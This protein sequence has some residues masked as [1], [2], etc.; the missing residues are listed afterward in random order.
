[1][2]S[3]PI[4]R[5]PFDVTQTYSRI[6]GRRGSKCRV[7]CSIHAG[8]KDHE[9]YASHL[10]RSPGEQKRH[11]QLRRFSTPIQIQPRPKRP[12]PARDEKLTWESVGVS[13]REGGRHFKS[14]ESAARPRV[15]HDPAYWPL[16]RTFVRSASLNTDGVANIITG[17]AAAQAKGCHTKFS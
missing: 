2:E 15:L 3:W 12:E 8:P 9:I 13:L 7:A 16:H 17:A 6:G 10:G 14:S 5:S 1:M 4:T 11:V